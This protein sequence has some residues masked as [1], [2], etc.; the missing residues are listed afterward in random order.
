[1]AT[2]SPDGIYYPISTTQIAPLE[3][4]F[5]TLATSVQTA[6]T[7]RKFITVA[8]ATALDA[9]S[10]ATYSGYVVN[11]SSTGTAW[12]SNG[13]KWI[14]AN[15]PVVADA[16]ARNALYTGSVTVTQGDTVFRNDLGYEETYFALY[17]VST[18][19]GGRPAAGWFP[20]LTPVGSVR[21]VVST[22]RTT[23]SS[24]AAAV[25]AWVDIT[26]MTATITPT[27]AT[28]KILVMFDTYIGN[29]NGG[30]SFNYVQMV[31][32]STAIG[33]GTGGT[34]NSSGQTYITDSGRLEPITM[35][36][37]D[38]PA[39]TS[40]TT[41]K[42]QYQTTVGTIYLNRRGSATD[43]ITAST[44]TLIEVAA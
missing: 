25:G 21:Q 41:Y 2:T 24:S 34:T 12:Y 7:A 14:L 40:A 9:L 20:E 36:F 17:N 1:M 42:L 5:A 32:G 38:S 16:T 26:G 35:S 3:T 19:P 13:T 44:I 11:V 4:Q 31:R 28:S 18:N 15:V 33:V 30:A 37:L 23:T 8:N 22:T 29:S 39:T 43:L 10:E 6:L 27:S